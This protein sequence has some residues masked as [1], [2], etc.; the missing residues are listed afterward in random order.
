ML[1]LTLVLVSLIPHPSSAGFW[2]RSGTGRGRLCGLCL[3][4]VRSASQPSH[5]PSKP[6]GL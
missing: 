3:S 1:T 2:L 6:A 5:R 4:S